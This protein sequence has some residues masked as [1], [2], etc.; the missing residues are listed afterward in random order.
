MDNTRTQRPY[1]KSVRLSGWVY[2]A[3]DG[4]KMTVKNISITGALAELSNTQVYPYHDIKHVFEALLTPKSADFYLPPLRLSGMAKITRVDAQSDDRILLALAFEKTATGL[5]QP[6]FNRKCYRK[7]FSTLGCL[8]LDG[9]YHDF[10]VVNVG[11]GGLT[12]RLPETL[13]ASANTTALLAFKTLNLQGKVKII[14]AKPTDNAETLMGLQY[15][16]P[17]NNGADNTLLQ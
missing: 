9:G 12:I 10:V 16:K 1:R 8:L 17:K 13:V 11:L 14:W 3:G 6:V 4:R 2:L 15:I 5:K 7:V